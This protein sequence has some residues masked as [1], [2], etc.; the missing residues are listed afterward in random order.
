MEMIVRHGKAEP[1]FCWC[2]YGKEGSVTDNISNGGGAVMIDPTNGITYSN[3]FNGVCDPISGKQVVGI[4]IPHWSE[5][6][7]RAVSVMG[8][9]PQYR[10]LAFDFALSKEKGWVLI[11]G[12][13]LG[14][15]HVSGVGIS[16]AHTMQAL[17]QIA[18]EG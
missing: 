3:E 8:E 9:F 17:E 2:R 18:K 15:F 7:E 5:L 13:G 12:N 16:P 6:V 4:Q 1:L 10:L 11:E 14:G